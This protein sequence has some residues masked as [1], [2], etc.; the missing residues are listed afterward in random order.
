MDYFFMVVRIKPALVKTAS[1]NIVL[2]QGERGGGGV[3]FPDKMF[4]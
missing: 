4:F 2:N 3:T 1:L